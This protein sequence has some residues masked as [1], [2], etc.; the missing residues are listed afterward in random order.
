MSARSISEGYSFAP[1]TVTDEY[2]TFNW[3]S[4]LTKRQKLQET[5]RVRTKELAM[6]KLDCRISLKP[7]GARHAVLILFLN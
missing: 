7:Q 3:A 5:L 4:M 1:P 6:A 2:A